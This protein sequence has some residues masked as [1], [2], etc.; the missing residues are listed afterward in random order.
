MLGEA[1]RTHADA[2]RYAKAYGDALDTIAASRERR[3]QAPRRA[4]R[5]S[6]ARSTR[7]MNGATP[8]RPRRRSLPV[9]R[10]LARRPPPPTSTSPS[11]PRKPTGSNCRSTS[12]R[13]WSP[14]TRLFAN[15]WGGFGLALQAYAKRAVPLGRLGRRAGA[16]ARPQADGP[17]GQGRLLGQRD[18]GRAGR[19]PV[20]L[21]GVHAQ[22]RD[23]RQLHRLCQGDAGG[24]RRALF[25]LCHPQ[26][27][28]HRRDQGARGHDPVRVPAPP[29]HGRRALRRGGEARAR[30][31]AIRSP[32]CASTPPSAATRNCSPTSS[33]GL[34]EN[35]ANSS[36]VNRIADDDVPVEALVRDPVAELAALA[37]TRNPAIPLPDAIFSRPPQQRRASTSATRSS[38]IR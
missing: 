28:Y 30:R 20:R 26:C 8:R 15:G 2:A 14:T 25:G 4:F 16:Q 34:L 32:R 6:C 17:A 29:R 38:A 22:G 27:Q 12:S 35:G 33:A 1:A 19:R 3:V 31:S 24:Q 37:P 5:S 9:V 36:F 13:R 18:Q 21:S 10:D 7:A 11:T 23:R